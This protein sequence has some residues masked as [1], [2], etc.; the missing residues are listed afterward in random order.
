VENR[1]L[2]VIP[3]L[4]SINYITSGGVRVAI[5]EVISTLDTHKNA[6]N[7]HNITKETVKLEKV[8]NAPMD[9]I[10]TENS[11]N[12]ISSGGVDT[13]IKDIKAL[14]ST[15][16]ASLNSAINTKLNAN[17]L[18]TDLTAFSNKN[19]KY[20]TA[21]EIPSN[22]ITEEMLLAKNYLTTVPSNYVTVDELAAKEYLTTH[23]DISGK[24]NK[25]ELSL[26]AF[27]GS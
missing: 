4:D 14:I 25:A 18:P 20:I 3:K 11:V 8:V 10:P 26:V 15:E 5:N 2:D 12:Y 6:I 23:Q 17:D 7:P 24:A 22:Y 16:V 19:T 21:K 13:A 1:P 27:S 9:T